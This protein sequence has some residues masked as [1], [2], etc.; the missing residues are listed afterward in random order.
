MVGQP[1]RYVP[2]QYRDL[3]AQ[4]P[5][6]A[7][8]YDL[9]GDACRHAGPLSEREQ[10][11]IKLGVAVGASSKGA[12]RSHMRRGLDEGLSR[13]ELLHAIAIAIPT[14]G[15]PATAAAYRWASEVPDER[16]DAAQPAHRR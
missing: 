11:L 8:A 15:L 7:E 2:R 5:A 10:R 9:L 13:E 16:E 12:V 4:H 3:R 14:L 1:R 6:I